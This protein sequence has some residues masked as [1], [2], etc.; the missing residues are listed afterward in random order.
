M[1]YK[2]EWIGGNGETGVAYAGAVF[3]PAD[4]IHERTDAV[5]IAAEIQSARDVKD[6]AAAD[7]AR[8][9]ALRW[10]FKVE[11]G[12]GYTRLVMPA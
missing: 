6:Y 1:T 4:P 7:A 3:D 11:N 12:A 8:A 2:H 10:G 9:K 5:R